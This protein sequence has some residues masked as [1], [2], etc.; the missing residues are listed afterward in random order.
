MKA[1][2]AFALS[3]VVAASTMYLY[4]VGGDLLPGLAH[5]AALPIIALGA[6]FV[7]G[8]IMGN[9][10]YWSIGCGAMLQ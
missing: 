10:Y 2:S 8:R 6:G 7:Q 5:F 1:I 3:F 9:Q 4:F